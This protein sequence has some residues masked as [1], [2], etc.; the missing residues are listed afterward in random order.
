MMPSPDN[1]HVLYRAKFQPSKQVDLNQG[2]ALQEFEMPSLT[3]L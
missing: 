3:P 1:R 2:V